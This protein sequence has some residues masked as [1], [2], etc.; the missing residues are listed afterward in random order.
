MRAGSDADELYTNLWSQ[1]ET[2]L[3]SEMQSRGRLN[4][5]RLEWF[6]IWEG[7]SQTGD[8]IDIGRLYAGYRRCVDSKAGLYK[9]GQ[10]LAF[11]NQ[12]AEHYKAL[13]TGAGSSAIR[14]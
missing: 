4:R 8:D 9:A 5:P 1:F 12:Y 6:F 3:W 13:V 11:L 10:Q 7:A 14:N 2:P